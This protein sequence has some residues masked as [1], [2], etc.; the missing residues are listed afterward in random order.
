MFSLDVQRIA[1]SIKKKVSYMDDN[2]VSYLVLSAL[3]G[4]YIGFG[5][6][7]VFN[8]GGPFAMDGSVA[9][10]L[11]MGTSF[12]VALTLVVFAGCELFTGNNMFGVLGAM[13]G[14]ISW[15]KFGK[16]LTLSLIGNFIGSVFIAYLVVKS[17]SVSSEA[18]QFLIQKASVAKMNKPALDLFL[19]GILCNWLVC[20][21]L[22]A[23][24][25]TTNEVAKIFLIFWCLFAFIGSG[26]EHS[27]ANQT[28]LSLALFSPHGELVTWGGFLWNQVWVILGN[29]VG[30]SFFVGA[31]Y[32]SA[33]AAL[34]Q[35]AIVDTVSEKKSA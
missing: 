29:L 13:C 34:K 5:I 8:V 33:S 6:T 1:Q 2:P 16:I 23:S 9:T 35:E 31:T 27:I 12:G 32:W 22:W 11:V 26:F 10:K 20:L 28:L 14:E 7:L 17:G 21:A 4:I 30:G 24:A 3:A 19:L 18:T 25:R 15:G